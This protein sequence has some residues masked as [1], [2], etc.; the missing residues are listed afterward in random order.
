MNIV[1]AYIKFNK[2]LII[3]IS[4]LSGSEKTV[5]AKFIERDFKLKLINLENYVNKD[6]N[7]TVTLSN[8]TK[9]INWDDVN[10]Y[11][12]NKF[13]TDVISEQTNGIVVS[14]CYFPLNK[15]KFDTDFHIHIKVPKQTLIEKRTKFAENK[16]EKFNMDTTLI[17]LI[18]NQITYPLYL[19]YVENS[20]I[21]KYVNSKDLTVD[22]IYDQVA[23]F[24]FF[25]IDENLNKINSNNKIVDHQLNNSDNLNNSNDDSSE[26]INNNSDSS[27]TISHSSSS[28]LNFKSTKL[29]TP[30]NNQ[31]FVGTDDNVE[32][33][34]M[35]F[36]RVGDRIK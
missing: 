24:L 36:F 30:E 3:I 28:T 19:T 2:K 31:V 21:D 26:S 35:D 14:G 8:D 20:K 4:G 17:P 15:I 12:W 16:K 9:L 34:Q 22:Q 1:E 32:L 29:L 6:F 33:D 10:S 5:I 18:V 11:D 25:K 13:N 7:E 23:D 27:E